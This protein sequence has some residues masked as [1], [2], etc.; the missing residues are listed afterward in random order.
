M[1]EKETCTISTIAG[2]HKIEP[3]ARNDPRE[4]DPLKLNLPKI[5]SMDYFDNCL[6]IPEWDGDMILLERV[7]HT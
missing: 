5:S 1:I 3:H 2:N 7:K 4:K 6:F